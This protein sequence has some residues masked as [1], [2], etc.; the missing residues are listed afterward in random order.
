MINRRI[1]LKGGA[2]AVALAGLGVGSYMAIRPSLLQTPGVSRAESITTDDRIPERA[3]VAIIGGG[4]VGIMT[5]MHLRD[6]GYDVVV[7]EKGVIAGE[8]SSRA[9]GW[10]SSI[11]DEPRRLGLAA[12]SGET[13]RGINEKLG[14]DTSYRQ[15]GL[16]YECRD[17]AAIA[18]WEQWAK[19]HPDQGGGEI[20]ILR[21]AELAER[22]PGGAADKWYAAV[23]QPLDGSVEPPAAAPRIASAL[24]AGGARVV[25]NCAVRGIETSGGA[26]SAVVTEKGT[27]ACGAV[28]L[29]GGVGSRLFL[30]NLGVALPILRVYS[31]IFRIPGFENGPAGAGAGA[32]T[33]W[34]KEVDGGYSI[35]VQTRYA[36]ILMDNFRF[37]PKFA[38]T[39]YDNWSNFSIEPNREF[40]QDIA[41][42]K[43]WTNT[44]ESPFERDRIL[45]PKPNKPLAETALASFKEAFPQAR[46][47][48]PV[49]EWGGVIDI[50]P[51]SAPII[52]KIDEIPG[53]IVAAGMSGHGLSMAPAAG[54]L[55]AE[56]IA[57]ETTMVADPNAYRMS[58]F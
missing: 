32:G 22:L 17:D 18:R 51:D 26:V 1:L 16:M 46:A 12:P 58:R 9:F 56:L 15:N 48:Q 30:Q 35:G 13:W 49:E 4:I 55:V 36:P 38:G 37:L 27:I 14:V 5:A 31:Y 47:V 29:S 41:A 52:Q 45:A 43:S 44:E 2:G 8:Q 23:L 21:G 11:G 34:R 53:L 50:T 7:L 54:Q 3:D 24:I 10:I 39:L 40:Y 25:Q 19:D 33:A 20:R 42:D 57:N 6:K 28:V